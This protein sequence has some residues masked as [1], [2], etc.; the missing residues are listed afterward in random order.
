MPVVRCFHAFY[1]PSGIASRVGTVT[2]IILPMFQKA[3][4]RF[5]LLSEELLRMFHAVPST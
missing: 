3:E 1:H 4:K 2:W 5:I